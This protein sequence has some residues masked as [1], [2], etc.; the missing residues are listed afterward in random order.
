MPTTSAYVPRALSV[1][2]SAR[3]SPRVRSRQKKKRELRTRRGAGGPTKSDPLRGTSGVDQTIGI[4]YFSTPDRRVCK[5]A[6]ACDNPI[7]AGQY[8][9]NG[10]VD[11]RATDRI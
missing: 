6:L 1:K 7:R 8:F 11:D 9:F 3:L 10:E 2:Q 5:A 4:L